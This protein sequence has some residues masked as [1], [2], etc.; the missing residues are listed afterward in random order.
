MRNGE[1][2]ELRRVNHELHQRLDRHHYLEKEL[3][4]A[5]QRLE[6]MSIVVQ[7]KMVAEK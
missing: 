7:N 5:R 1:I 6:E 4:K 2:Q 3:G